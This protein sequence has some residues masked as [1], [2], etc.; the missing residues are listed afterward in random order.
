[1]NCISCGKRARVS[2][3]CPKCGTEIARCSTCRRNEV[4]Y[5]CRSCNEF[6]GP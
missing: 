3:K 1:M 2:F 6:T 4:A 5:K